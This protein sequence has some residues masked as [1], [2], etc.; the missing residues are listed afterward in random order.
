MCVHTQIYKY[1]TMNIHI[2]IYIPLCIYIYTYTYVCIG[3]V[4]IVYLACWSTCQFIYPSRRLPLAPPIKPV[5]M[6]GLP[7]KSSRKNFRPF[8]GGQALV[9]AFRKGMVCSGTTLKARDVSRVELDWSSG[10]SGLIKRSCKHGATHR[11]P[12]EETTSKKMTNFTWESCP[13]SFWGRTQCLTN[14]QAF[15]ISGKPRSVRMTG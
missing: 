10:K 12:S 3:G 8:C 1:I 11:R 15:S 13:L 6:P 4:P 14:P 5:K 9:A 2:Q 7:R